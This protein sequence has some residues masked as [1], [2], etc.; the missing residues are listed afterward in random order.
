[1]LLTHL[2]KVVNATNIHATLHYNGILYA[3][4][5]DLV[6][7]VDTGLYRIPYTIPGEAETGTYTLMVKAE[8]F[9][10]EDACIKSFLISPTLSSAIAQITEIKD[11]IATVITD[12]SSIKVN[13]TSIN[14]KLVSIEGSVALID[15]KIGTL[16]TDL[17]NINATITNIITGSKG[18]ILAEIDSDF[19]SITTQLD[20]IT[21]NDSTTM[22]GLWIASVF[23]LIAAIAALFAVALLR[24]RIK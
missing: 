1:V 23:S 5:S 11:G 20:N 8:Y 14:A 10:V 9:N 19:G 12:L 13:L 2:G 16:Q 6:E 24:R 22:I 4:L 7:L 18:E 3:D 17:T 21:A 15:S